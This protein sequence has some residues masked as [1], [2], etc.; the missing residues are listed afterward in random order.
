LGHDSWGVLKTVNEFAEKFSVP[1]PKVFLINHPSAQIFCYAKTSRSAH[2][3]VT[4]GALKLLSA[5]ELRAALT[6]Q[7]VTMGSAFSMLNYWLAATIDLFFRLGR[8]LEKLFAFVF[9][10]TPNIASVMVGPWIWLMQ[11]LLLGSR[12]FQNL[13]RATVAEISSPEYLAQAIWKMESYAQTR[14]WKEAVVFAHMC[15]VSPFSERRVSRLLRVQPSVKTRIT[16]L[17]GHYPI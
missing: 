10:A 11:K 12:D 2:L 8:G 1:V 7:F 13:D 6:F 15:M 9:G 14:P 5:Q 16:N 17:L 4:D 3:Y